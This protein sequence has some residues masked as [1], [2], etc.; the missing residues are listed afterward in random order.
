MALYSF[1]QYSIHNLEFVHGCYA[2]LIV[3]PSML[4]FIISCVTS[5]VRPDVQGLDNRSLF[6]RACCSALLVHPEGGNP[7][8]IR[9]VTSY[10]SVVLGYAGPSGYSRAPRCERV[11]RHEVTAMSVSDPGQRD[12]LQ[13]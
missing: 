9:V 3:Y 13:T 8:G 7:R 12:C 10:T 6:F 2:I 11:R 5:M 4:M 1:C